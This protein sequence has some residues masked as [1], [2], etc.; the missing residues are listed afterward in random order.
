MGALDT[1]IVNVALP[2]IRANM[3]ATVTEITWISTG[4]I[5]ALV[6]VMP[7][8]AWLSQI[9]GRK[10]LYMACL[11]LFTVSSFLCGAAWSLTSLIVFRVIQ[12]IGAGVMMPVQQAILRET[13][14]P[15]QQGLAMGIFGVAVMIGPAVGP[16]L[17]GWITDNYNWPWIFYVN[18]P[19]GFI[20]LWMVNSFIHDPAHA[21][22]RRSEA[23]IDAAGIILL[24]VGLAALQTVLEQGQSED[25]FESRF[26]IA[27]TV[28]ATIALLAFVWWELRAEKPVV[29]LRLLREATF[30][31][32]TFIGGI[33]GVSL[34]ASMFLLPLFLQELLG[35]PAL[36]SGLVMMPRALVMVPLMPIA[37]LLYNYVGTRVMIGAGL[38][39]AGSAP[40]MMARFNLD[41]TRM[42]LLW[43]Q[44][45]QGIG[46]ALIFVALSTT[47]LAVIDRRKLTA[48]TGLYNLVRQLGGSFGTAIFASMLTNQQQVAR[49]QLV[50]FISP[51]RPAY[52]LQS[53]T[54]YQLGLVGRGINPYDAQ[55]K[56]LKFFEGI[57]NQQAA[58]LAFDH[59]FFVI[60]MLFLICLPL[61][62]L[63]K[64]NP[65]RH[66]DRHASEA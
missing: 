27:F 15:H 55:V 9:F 51:Y 23:G 26:I 34:F 24:T 56:T 21:R 49:A 62:L 57:V 40:L 7:L 50:K 10:R 1:S 36:T 17:G 64:E 30:A 47:S 60:G 20:G 37:G 16:T 2:Y 6:I 52:A 53:Q 46:F 19:I 18:V 25:W 14:P 4:Y 38:L 41:S 8:T 43:P 58:V 33:L 35:Y 29:E 59:T 28:V 32:G 66:L 44:M 11:A 48:A 22:A 39:I 45:T 13:Y 42:D 5:I 31:T 61:V 63:L 54:L 12:G 3:G 65:H